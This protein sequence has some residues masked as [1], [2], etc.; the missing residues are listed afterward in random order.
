M[1]NVRSG[2]STFAKALVNSFP[3]IFSHV[4]QDQL[5]GSRRA[6]EGAVGRTIRGP[7][8]LVLDRCN[9]KASDR[10]AWLE[11]AMQKPKDV[12]VMFSDAL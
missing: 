7:Q 1:L 4:N 6:T 5:D 11:L 9:F 12:T 3:D 8:H 2:K 10:R